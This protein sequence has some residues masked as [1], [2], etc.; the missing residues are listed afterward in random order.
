MPE[1]RRSQL[2][3]RIGADIALWYGLP[4]LFLLAYVL[5]YSVPPDAVVPHLKV[6]TFGLLSLVLV[7]L[8]LYYAIPSPLIRRCATALV[9]SVMLGSMGLYYVLVLI[10]L[11]SW[12]RVISWDLMASYAAQAPALADALGVSLILA[13]SV[14]ALLFAGLLAASF[15][16]LAHFDWLPP[17]VRSTSGWLLLPLA[18]AAGAAWASGL[19]DF[20][21]APWTREYEPVSLTLFP[22]ERSWKLQGHV[23]DG[24]SSAKLDRAEDLARASYQPAPKKS[25]RNLI[26]VVVDAMRPDHMGVYGYARDTTPFLGQLA[27]DGTMRKAPPVHA[28]CSSSSCGLLSLSSSKFVHQ[29][30]THPFTL[31]QALKLHGYRV[32]MILGGDHTNFYNLKQSYGDVDTY[33]DGN[34]ARRTSYMNDDQL[35]LNRLA[36]FPQWDGVPVMMQFHLMAIHV[37]GKRRP[38]STKFLPATNYGY[39]D[40]R[41]PGPDGR[42]GQRNVNYYDNGVVQADATIKDILRI[43]ESKG[44]LNDAVVAITA[45]HGE[46]LGEHGFFMHQN[47]VHE[48][49]LHI[50]FLLISYGYRG[51]RVIDKEAYP[52]QIDLAPTILDELGLPRPTTWLGFPLQEPAFRE[53]TYFQERLDVGLLDHRDPK[54]LWKYWVN[55][56]SGKEH[57]FNLTADPA[58]NENLV[59]SVPKDRLREW[60][61]RVLPGSTV[62][63]Y[64]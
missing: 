19:Y 62:L 44:Y 10:G 14:L 41:D 52:S 18:V 45:D 24:L 20:L 36:E 34:S 47:S 6:V 15:I 46:S 50:P 29:F 22:M 28:S 40:G 9:A 57:A 49:V 42:P 43:L 27:R 23:I 25:H 60:R 38:E 58:E 16:Y 56:E 53:F 13:T 64:H 1:M 37:L 54:N 5:R 51:A 39:P 21:A 59:N 30:S 32:H 4:A 33:F 11:Q 48:E 63:V 12:G 17:A 3:R 26:L 35:I 31:Q 55:T 8:G 7:R 2:L 61:L